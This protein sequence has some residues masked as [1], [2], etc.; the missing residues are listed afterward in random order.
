MVNLQLDGLLWIST[1][2]C[3]GNYK[4]LLRSEQVYVVM[5]YHVLLVPRSPQ[6]LK[7]S[8]NAPVVILNP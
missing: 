5:L 3:G 4:N 7:C 6:G 8:H 2:T 1:N